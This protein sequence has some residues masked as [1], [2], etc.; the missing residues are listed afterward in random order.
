[1]VPA[2]RID[3]EENP[4]TTTE[5]DAPTTAD[6]LVERLFSAS[7]EALELFSVHLGVRLGLYRSLDAAAGGLT[8]SELAA[9]AGIAERYAVE[10]LEQQAVAGFVA[11]DDPAAPS[12]QRRYR[13][14]A[15]HRGVLVDPDDSGHVAPLASMLAGI[16]GVLVELEDAYRSGAGVAYASYGHHFRDGQGGINRPALLEDLPGPWL[17]AMPDVV[18]SLRAGGARVADVGCGQGWAAI[19]VAEAFPEAEIV[20][21]DADAASVADARR[22]AAPRGLGGRLAFA[23]ADAVGI[24]EHGPFDLIVMVEV[25]HDVARPVELLAG[26]RDALA[27]GGTV[28]VVDEKVADHFVAP[29][30]DVERMMYGWSVLHCLPASLAER[31]SA[32]TGTCMRSGTVRDYA[33]KAG[34]TDAEVLA[35]DNDLFRFYRLRG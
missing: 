18:A 11:F 15:A 4:M 32:G 34:F 3:P 25:L 24:A 21:L 27:E 29:G 19:G 17:A 30:D 12:Q 22:N 13:L 23:A 26:C 1:M 8:A 10:W 2:R 7:I 16:G 33:Q 6:V 20:G 31:P 14:P 9:A 5:P 35:V 28:L